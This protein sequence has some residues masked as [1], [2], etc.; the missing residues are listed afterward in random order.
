V[1]FVVGINLT[2]ADHLFI[3]EPCLN[4]ALERQVVNRAHR[5]GQK[6]TLHVK[7][8]IMR[9][10]IEKKIIDVNASRDDGTSSARSTTPTVGGNIISDRR[11]IRYISVLDS[12][13][14]V[15]HILPFI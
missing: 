3:M 8:L 7:R 2:S 5:I 14:L 11:C 1:F 4:P 9:N 6:R 12:S 10:T 15:S 13:V